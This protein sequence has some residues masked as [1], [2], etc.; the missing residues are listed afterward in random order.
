MNAADAAGATPLIE[1]SRAA[2]VAMA[3]T[4][5]K[6]RADVSAADRDGTTALLVATKSGSFDLFDA[7]I[8]A[9]LQEE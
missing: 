1:A 7:L 2:S 5:L 3:T 8:Q 6:A 4:L 9:R